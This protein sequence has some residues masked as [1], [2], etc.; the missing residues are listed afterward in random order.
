MEIG[1]QYE[2]LSSKFAFKR[3]EDFANDSLWL[4]FNNGKRNLKPKRL[5]LQNEYEIPARLTKTTVLIMQVAFERGG[6]VIARTD[7]KHFFLRPSI[8]GK[9]YSGETETNPGE[10]DTED[11]NEGSEP[12]GILGPQ[13]IPGEQGAKG[14]KGDPGP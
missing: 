11:D 7:K 5:D 4:L 6:K 8:E 13:G 2:N 14:D 10:Q 9:I 1:T 12:Q 3:P